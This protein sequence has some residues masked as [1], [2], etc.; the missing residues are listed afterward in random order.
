LVPLK[1]MFRDYVESQPFHSLVNLSCYIDDRTLLTKSGDV[2]CMMSLCGPDAE[3]LEPAELGTAAAR[4]TSSFRAFGPGFVVNSH[5]IK[6]GDPQF[7]E[8]SHASPFVDAALR[9]RRAFLRERRLQLFSYETYLVVTRKADWRNAGSVSIRDFLKNPRAAMRGAYSTPAQV[10]ILHEHVEQAKASL[11]RATKSFIDQISDRFVARV[12]DRGES[13]AFLRRL[14]NPDRE[15][16]DAVR[17]KSDRHVDFHVVS[18]EL[19]CQRNHL[20]L[21]ETFVKVLTLKDPPS[22][23][24]VNI[25]NPLSEVSADLVVVTEWQ[26]WDASRAAPAIRSK[27]RHFHNTKIGISS[28]VLSERPSDRHVLFDDSKEAFVDDL[29]R[30]VEDI[31]MG[32][33][34][35]GEFSL[36]VVVLGRTLEAAEKACAEV[37]RVFG[38]HDGSV[39]EETYNNLN[40]FLATIPGGA[41]FNL[42]KLLVT[43]RNHVDLGLWWGPFAG[44]AH[45]VFFDAPALLTF[46]TEQQSLFDFNLHVKDV[47]HALVLGMT[48][49]GKS[50]QLNCLLTHAQKY[51]PYTFIFD[52]GGSYRWLTQ[53]IN[54]SYVSVRPGALPFSINPYALPVTPA[55]RQFQFDF[56]KMLIESGEYRISVAEEKDVWDAIDALSV[57]DWD[58]HRLRTLATTVGPVLGQHLKR[59]TEG[60]QYGAWFDHVADTVTFARLQCF[61]FEGM[62]DM[63]AALEPVLFYLLHRANDIV[64]DPARAA[65][66]KLCV[67]DEAWRFC[68][69]PIT[70]AYIAT[71]LRTWRKKNAAMI[72]AT[73]S[74]SDL[75]DA[76][77][78]RPIL[79]NCPTKILLANPTLDAALYGDVLK[80]SPSEQARVR[81]LIPKRQFLL[82]RDGISK[83]LNLNVDPRS[84]W[85]FTTNPFEAQR[86]D[87]A[88][89]ANGLDAALDLLAGGSR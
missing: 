72:L 17:V 87:E 44:E 59:W 43:D 83:V 53:A 61:D 39:I 41:P 16:A 54:G 88:V 66:F 8:E 3:S 32:G 19:A 2:L 76:E 21:D 50:F 26:P 52:V 4:L 12:L 28:Q 80:L 51:Q 67:V 24:F 38:A 7:A 33:T 64:V 31:E 57:L 81:N 29:G 74:V 13:F 9:N 30:C 15:K 40:A 58:Q 89:A 84:Y 78:L 75:T 79:D 6:R 56:T 69:N 10:D 42:R 36:S 14:L 20:R 86:R 71:A 85:L 55:N 65:E 18:S 25:L 70:R 49:T 37:T 47:G 1:S 45:N 60:E 23:S 22:H 27:R 46:E 62:E 35:I 77:G 68:A 82:K 11:Q 63:G 34:Q 5:W 48:G 73:Q